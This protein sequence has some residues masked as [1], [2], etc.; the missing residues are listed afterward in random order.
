ML[1]R[2][3]VEE[4]IKKTLKNEFANEDDNGEDEEKVLPSSI[5]QIADD[6]MISLMPF[7]MLYKHREEKENDRN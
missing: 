7:E 2:S 1:F 3:P 6:L 5:A 4:D